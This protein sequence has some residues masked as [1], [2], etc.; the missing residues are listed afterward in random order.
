MGHP[1]IVCP[2][3]RAVNRV[4]LARARSG[5]SCGQC[6]QPL[7]TG[8]PVELDEAGFPTVVQRTQIPVIVDF[9]APWCG[10]CRAMAPQF[11]KA[12]RL[13]EPDYRLAK[14]DTEAQPAIA[15]RFAIRSI[16]TLIMFDQGVEV[17]RRVGATDLPTLVAWARESHRPVRPA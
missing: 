11:E 2:A 5:A 13:L 14:V 3:C 7:F 17:A 6:R 4:D 8:R 9:W 12:A 16:P 10:P 15:Q 1:H